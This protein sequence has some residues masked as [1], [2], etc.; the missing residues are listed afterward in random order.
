MPATQRQLDAARPVAPEPSSGL[1]RKPSGRASS[2]IEYG[3]TVSRGKAG[4]SK[5]PRLSPHSI[6]NIT[7]VSCVFEAPSQ[8]EKIIDKLVRM[9]EAKDRKNPNR[10][11]Y[12]PKAIF[13]LASQH[14]GIPEDDVVNVAEKYIVESLKWRRFV[15]LDLTQ[16]ANRADEAAASVWF[17]RSA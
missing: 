17:R 6:E 4:P 15:R 1:T 14:L 7:Q 9:I 2:S 10:P 12:A 11:K 16:V 3:A 13:R 8:R 5:A